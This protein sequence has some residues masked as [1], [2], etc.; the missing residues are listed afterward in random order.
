VACGQELEALYQA[1]FAPPA[2]EPA[3][4]IG[5]DFIGRLLWDVHTKAGKQATPGS[6]HCGTGLVDAHGEGQ[7]TAR[8]PRRLPVPQHQKGKGWPSHA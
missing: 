7:P 4:R 1:Q 3:G 8:H 5:W 2:P 6:V